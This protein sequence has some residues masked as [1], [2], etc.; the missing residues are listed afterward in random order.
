MYTP[1]RHLAADALHRS[2]GQASVGGELATTLLAERDAVRAAAYRDGTDPEKITG[3][4][5]SGCSVTS[6]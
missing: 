5:W 4:R 6:A 3:W 1:G 2:R